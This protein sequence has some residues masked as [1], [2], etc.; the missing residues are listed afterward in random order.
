MAKILVTGAGGFVGANFTRALIARGDDVHVIL[1]TE[2]KYW[3]L[4]DIVEQLTIHIADLTKGKDI[5]EVVSR[6]KPDVVYHFA[7]YGGNRGESNSAQIRSVIIDGTANLYMACMRHGVRKIVHSGSSSEY[8]RKQTPMAEDMIL[9]PNTEYGLAKSWATLYGEHLHREKGINITTLRLFSVY[10]PYEAPT[11]LFP[12]V[13]NALLEG[14]A[15]TLSNKDTARDFIYIDDVIN[16][17]FLAEEGPG[18]VF[19]IGTGTESTLEHVVSGIQQVMN[20]DISLTWGSME[21]QS[22]DTSRWVADM[23]KTLHGLNFKV[24]TSLH[25]GIIKTVSWFQDN[26]HFYE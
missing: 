4:N 1:R 3:R 13:I 17:L 21:G 6:T 5:D 7:H 20:T 24:E 12:S 9:E 23:T 19:N 15:P 22:F 14:D 18:G 25:D 16:A 26:K 8:G 11:R 2:K 10:G